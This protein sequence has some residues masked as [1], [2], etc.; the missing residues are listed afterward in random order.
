M[1]Y[2]WSRLTF[3]STRTILG[4]KNRIGNLSC[5]D[6]SAARLAHSNE[7]SVL[8]VPVL[9]ITE[10]LQLFPIHA[11]AASSWSFFRS[12]GNRIADIAGVNATA[13][14]K[15]N[16]NFNDLLLEDTHVKPLVYMLQQDD[17]SKCT[18]A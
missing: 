10:P 12:N 4:T 5:P 17:P 14:P 13:E 15:A 18:A 8:P 7:I 16:K 6:S 3:C 11:S 9:K 2:V 1:L